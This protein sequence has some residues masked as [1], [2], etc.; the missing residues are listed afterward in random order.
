MRYSVGGASALLDILAVGEQTQSTSVPQTSASSTVS[1]RPSTLEELLSNPL[2]D[3]RLSILELEPQCLHGTPLDEDISLTSDGT[4]L[5]ESTLRSS[6]LAFELIDETSLANNRSSVVGRETT[7]SQQ[8]VYPEPT[9]AQQKRMSMNDARMKRIS[10]DDARLQCRQG[11]YTEP[12]NFPQQRRSSLLGET[13]KSSDIPINDTWPTLAQQRKMKEDSALRISRLSFQ[14]E[15]TAARLPIDEFPQA[16]SRVSVHIN[17]SR[18]SGVPVADIWPTAAQ[19]RKILEDSAL[20][21]NRLSFQAGTT[22]A[23]LPI[24]EFAQ[25]GSRISVHINQSRGNGV[26]VVDNWPTAAQQREILE[27][28]ALR[29]SRLSFHPE[30]TPAQM[31]RS[32]PLDEFPTASTRIPIHDNQSKVFPEKRISVVDDDV[33]LNVPPIVALQTQGFKVDFEFTK[34]PESPQTT[35][36]KALFSNT[37]T[38]PYTDFIFQAAVPK[39]S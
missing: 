20:R 38:T 9:L 1:R 8:R 26:P 22:A 10:L 11:S 12:S 25:S 33:P 2:P 4:S 27:D 35:I 21:I 16:G 13:L 17:Q 36:I 5:A 37:S 18:G 34:I 29:I 32:F 24:D 23:Q 28:S 15:T 30:P 39:V 31:H 14:S 19:Q 3:H 6:S 7:T